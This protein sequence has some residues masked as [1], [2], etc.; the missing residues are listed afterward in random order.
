MPTMDDRVDIKEITNSLWSKT[1]EIELWTSPRKKKKSP[2]MPTTSLNRYL[3]CFSNI[4][5]ARVE[6]NWMMRIPLASHI[7]KCEIA[8]EK[9]MSNW[10]TIACFHFVFSFI[11]LDC[12]I[13]KSGL[14]PPASCIGCTIHYE[15]ISTCP[16]GILPSWAWRYHSSRTSS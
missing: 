7:C 2:P 9:V 8:L 5:I 16:Y 12:L 3:V 1:N 13:W 11:C 6:L 4:N 15:R 10:V 14:L